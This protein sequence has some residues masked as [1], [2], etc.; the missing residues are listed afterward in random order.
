LP[1]LLTR[2]LK[3][4][5]WGGGGEKTRFVCGFLACDPRLGE[6]F[7]AGVPPVLAVNIRNGTAG[8]WLE[9]SIRHAVAMAAMDAPGSNVIVA[10]LSE[11]LFAETLRC[12][13]ARLPD[14]QTG[15]LAGARDPAVGQALA[16]LHARPEHPWSMAALAR[17][18]CLS[19]SALTDRFKHYLGVPPMT[20]RARWRLQLGAEALRSTS[21]GVAEIAGAVGYESEAAFN[22]AFKRAFSV[23]PARFR[24]ENGRVAGSARSHA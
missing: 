9:N 15:W 11:V 18:A 3:I 5:R 13:M 24:R 4:G 16:A 20:Y 7:L 19:R 10:K 14:E 17:E 21:R 23:P 12:H 1:D 8:D 2:R 6:V 22:R